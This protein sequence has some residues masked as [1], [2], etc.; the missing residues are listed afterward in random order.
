VLGFSFSSY[1]L[2]P[3][4]IC[5]NTFLSLSEVCNNNTMNL[6]FNRKQLHGRLRKARAIESCLEI[7]NESKLIKSGIDFL[8]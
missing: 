6:S 2:K 8:P 4:A 5:N 1:Y 3:L 7:Q